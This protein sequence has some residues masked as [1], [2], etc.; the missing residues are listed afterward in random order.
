MIVQYISEAQAKM[1]R[2]HCGPHLSKSEFL[3]ENPSVDEVLDWLRKNA[4]TGC[5]TCKAR[6][7]CPFNN[8]KEVEGGR[9]VR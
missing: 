6:R 8:R 5:Y 9:N 3:P 4:P 2:D 1:V 7:T